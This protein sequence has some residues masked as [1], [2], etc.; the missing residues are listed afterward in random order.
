MQTILSS[1]RYDKG[2]IFLKSPLIA[3]HV[4][5]QSYKPLEKETVN[6]NL[7]SINHLRS[8]RFSAEF[9]TK[10]K[11]MLYW[12]RAKIITNGC[13]PKLCTSSAEEVKEKIVAIVTT[14]SKGDGR[15]GQRWRP[16]SQVRFNLKNPNKKATPPTTKKTP[17]YTHT[18]TQS[19]HSICYF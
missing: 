12:W 1:S 7:F 9:I 2:K 18:L 5:G 16:Y 15:T 13:E 3:L 19:S 8:D 10:H 4:I 11:V 14:P 6:V 17:H